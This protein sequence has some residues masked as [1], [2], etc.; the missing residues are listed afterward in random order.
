M[1]RNTARHLA[2]QLSFAAS[3][4]GRSAQELAGDFFS[5]EHFGTLA[6]EDELY[7][8]LPDEKS[9][10][11]ILRLTS[12]IEAHRD[13]LDGHIARYARGWKL[14]RISRTALAVLRCAIC[15]ILY[16]EDVPLKAA[17]NEAV[18]LDK[19]Y[20]EP[21]TVAFV[22]GVLGGFARGEMGEKPDPAEE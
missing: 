10:N 9:L 13:E 18:E 16:L 17:I 3:A 21:E 19:L 4:S 8:E 1:T 22:N 6:G 5:E 20:D 2:I 7:A 11:Y 14:E 15:E 12:L